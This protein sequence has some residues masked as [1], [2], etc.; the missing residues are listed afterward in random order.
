MR[1]VEEGRPVGGGASWAQPQRRPA[2]LPR[3]DRPVVAPTRQPR[4]VDELVAPLHRP[5]VDWVARRWGVDPLDAAIGLGLVTPEAMIDRLARRIG[6]GVIRAEAAIQIAADRSEWRALRER[7]WVAI[8]R[9]VG[10]MAVLVAPDGATAERLAAGRVA[11]AGGALPLVLATEAAFSALLR[12]W[13]E[14]VW[15]EEAV[16]HLARGDP[17]ASAGD[18]DLMRWTAAL[19]ALGLAGLFAALAFAPPPFALAAGAAVGLLVVLW[20]AIRL[21]ACAIRPPPFPRQTL[22][23]A[24]LPRYTILCPLHREAAVVQALLAA[25]GGLDY[26]RAKLTILLLVEADDPDTRAAIVACRP[27][28]AVQVVVLPPDGPRTKPKALM[29]GLALADGDH[30]VVYDAEDRPGPGQLRE[31]AETFAAADASMGCLQAPLTMV[32]APGLLSRFF[33]AE[34]EALFRV[35]L[36]ALARWGWPLPL[37]GTSNHF[38][39]S[40][41]VAAGG[42]DPYN[43]TEDADLGFRLARHGFTTGTIAT[44]TREEPPAT[45]AGWIGQR[46]RWFKGW[47]QTL[48]VLARRPLHLHRE[49]GIGGCL[50]LGVT[51]AGSLLA[52]L[53][54]LVAL[55]ALATGW[56]LHGPPPWLGAA[57]LVFVAGYGGSLVFLA[58]GLARGGRTG[59]LPWLPLLPVVWLAM[60]LAA[61]MALRQLWSRPF[62]WEKTAHG[63]IAWPEDRRAAGQPSPV[64]AEVLERVRVLT[65][66]ALATRRHQPQDVAAA[67]RRHALRLKRGKASPSIVS[68]LEAM[69]RDL[70]GSASRASP[71]FERG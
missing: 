4:L 23:D 63:G 47:M 56:G 59:L 17:A 16:T 14:A 44:P 24:E 58:A 3:Q 51:L 67:L 68:G 43:V 5:R 36:P 53:V 13:A 50:A 40:A 33:A 37:G 55:A 65:E 11:I 71:P 32:D 34:Y 62:H 19:L 39:R 9:S 22:C 28:P 46:A 57:A 31:A 30:V 41:L 18:R 25:L 49:L 27:D 64:E 7:G 1:F 12:R 15:V 45:V 21:S 35:L 2:P 29:L 8:D 10:G 54:H 6:A 38:R 66:V 60:G 48:A 42:W 52:A 70:G 20:T 61:L 69:A 26:P